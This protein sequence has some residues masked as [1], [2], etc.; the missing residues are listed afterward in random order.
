MTTLRSTPPPTRAVFRLLG[1]VLASTMPTLGP[2][3]ERARKSCASLPVPAATVAVEAMDEVETM[4]SDEAGMAASV[5]LRFML[6]DG[7]SLPLTPPPPAAAAAANAKAD[8][9]GTML[10]EAGEAE[11]RDT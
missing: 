6:D 5:V 11:E 3:C 8:L 7:L 2:A 1:A 10:E 4:R 9:L